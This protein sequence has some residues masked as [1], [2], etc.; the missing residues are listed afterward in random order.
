MRAVEGRAR[1]LGQLVGGE[2][3]RSVSTT[4]WRLPWT[5]FLCS[6][7]FS[8]GLCSGGTGSSRFS[9]PRTMPFLTARLCSLVERTIG[10]LGRY[11]R[12]SKDY[13]ERPAS[14]ELIIPIAM[15]N[16]MVHRLEPD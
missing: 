11:R 3:K 4:T 5:R 16:S 13:E 6:I 2:S 7:G 9:P 1:A 14:E 12:S 15:I 8:H 10:W